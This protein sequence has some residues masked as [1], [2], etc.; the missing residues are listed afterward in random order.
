MY[1]V[2]DKGDFPYRQF[3]QFFNVICMG[4]SFF[5]MLYSMSNNP[6]EMKIIK[7]NPWIPIIVIALQAVNLFTIA[8][9]TTLFAQTVF[10][11][12]FLAG[13]LFTWSILGYNLV[14]IY[15]YYVTNESTVKFIALIFELATI[16]GPVAIYGVTLFLAVLAEIR[17]QTRYV[18]EYMPIRV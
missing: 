5:I 17:N 16:T 2:K 12:I 10:K 7:I 18:L 1:I 11:F 3:I 9:N 4:L 6:E 14:Q 15:H 8:C 13:A